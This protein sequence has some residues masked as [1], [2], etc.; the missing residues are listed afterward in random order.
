[1]EEGRTS[2]MMGVFIKGTVAVD[3]GD[4]TTPDTLTSTDNAYVTWT[5][6]HEYAEPGDYV[7]KLTVEGEMALGGS[8]SVKQYSCILRNSSGSDAINQVYQNAVKRVEIGNNVIAI[9]GNAFRNCMSLETITIPNGLKQIRDHAF[10][11][12]CAL[13]SITS[14][15]TIFEFGT[16]VFA[17]CYTLKSISIN[18]DENLLVTCIY[19]LSN[20]YL[21]SSITIPNYETNIRDSMFYNCHSLVSITIPNSVTSIG[22]N[23]FYNCCGVRYYDFT[24]H[25]AVPSLSAT[26]SFSGIAADCEIRV[27]AA[28]YDEWIAATNWATYA[29]KIVAV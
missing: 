6:K 16:N 13:K 17:N 9:S 22:S 28:L 5:P 14:P 23:V 19:G 29:S 18:E 8:S 10:N 7:I 27:P 4:G 12:C 15:N 3:W 21:L 20:C 25:T 11:T 2:P 24:N 26:S 1:L